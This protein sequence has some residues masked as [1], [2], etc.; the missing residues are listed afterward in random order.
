MPSNAPASNQIV[1]SPPTPK[2]SAKGSR[3]ASRTGSIA[4]MRGSGLGSQAGGSQAGD[5]AGT[6]G[7]LGSR[8]GSEA[9]SRGV[10]SKAGSFVNSL[11]GGGS[12]K[13]P[14]E[15]EEDELAGVDWKL[16]ARSANETVAR[17]QGDLERERAK[18][19]DLDGQNRELKERVADL[20]H[21]LEVSH[22]HEAHEE[23]KGKRPKGLLAKK[24]V[25]IKE[26]ES[27]LRAAM[28]GQAGEHLPVTSSTFSRASDVGPESSGTSKKELKEKDR[29]VKELKRRVDQLTAEKA[30]LEGQ[31]HVVAEM[32]GAMQNKDLLLQE[33][34]VAIIALEGKLKNAQD[35]I[36]SA[37]DYGWENDIKLAQARR[38]LASILE[39]HSPGRL[40]AGG[41]ERGS[42]T[43][44]KEKELREQL[45]RRIEELSEAKQ[46]AVEAEDY[47][48][49]QELHK[50]ITG[51]KDQLASVGAMSPSM[52]RGGYDS[53]SPT[54]EPT[55]VLTPASPAASGESPHYSPTR[56]TI[57]TNYGYRSRGAAG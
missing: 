10:M 6:D 23:E 50:E 44:Q 30:Q 41:T 32:R 21:Q 7:G 33:A 49:A 34:K 39:H 38:A 22:H 1:S 55:K 53:A 20:E 52:S 40:R 25:R 43:R 15:K 24:D 9:G 16:T 17:L 12:E 57:N 56:Y 31:G 13:A 18:S 28:Q 19:S 3:P 45:A 29:Q 26:L 14:S 51:L 48:D 37:T 11:L 27:Q 54:P 5:V 4:D 46:K 2:G 47:G 35:A 42:P 36:V 8:K